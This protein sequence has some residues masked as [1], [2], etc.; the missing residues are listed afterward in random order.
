MFSR[1]PGGERGTLVIAGH[2]NPIASI[3]LCIVPAARSGRLLACSYGALHCILF[4]KL[5]PTTHGRLL[6]FSELNAS[7]VSEL[8]AKQEV[9][10][11]AAAVFVLRAGRLLLHAAR[12]NYIYDLTL[13]SAAR[14]YIYTHKVHSHPRTHRRR[15]HSRAQLRLQQY[16]RHPGHKASKHGGG[17]ILRRGAGG[18][19]GEDG[20]AGRGQSCA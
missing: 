12:R 19:G 1:L 8:S 11:V 20:E 7:R 4:T 2:F 18:D 15:S 5:D 14:S 3:S 17:L 6:C 16:N 9:G 10:A 13:S